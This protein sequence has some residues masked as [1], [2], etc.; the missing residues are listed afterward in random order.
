MLLASRGGWRD[1]SYAVAASLAVILG[2][3]YLGQVRGWVQDALPGHYR[4]IVAAIV[5]LGAGAAVV[6][7]VA[8][9]RDRKLGRYLLLAAA[10]G[11]AVA[12]A[13]GARTGNP[14]QRSRRAVPFRR[15]RCGDLPVP[16]GVAASRRW[17]GAGAAAVRRPG[18]G[19]SDEWFQWFVP[20]R[21]GELHDVLIN[22]VAVVC[23]LLF[24]L[25]VHPPMLRRRRSL[26]GGGRS[27]P[28]AGRG[29]P[30]GSGVRRFGSSRLRGRRSR[31]GTFRSRFDRRGADAARS[32]ARRP[33]AGAA[34]AHL[35]PGLPA[36]T[37]T[38][39]K[40]QWH[41]QRRNEAAR[42]N[43][44]GGRAWHENTILETFFTPVLDLGFRW[45]PDAGGSRRQA[46]ALPDRASYR[47][48][49][50]AISDH[51][52]RQIDLWA[53]VALIVAGLSVLGFGKTRPRSRGFAS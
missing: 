21:V 14:D 32:R 42:G 30:D 44:L 9:I 34:A 12:Y 3:P 47:S 38:W 18:R 39:P 19:D 45:A 20:S 41:V 35:A 23:G 11:I 5:V 40:A 1:L 4:W 31:V 33:L 53:P 48:D 16:P 26:A 52:H 28:G 15:V 22:A 2:A 46:N 29:R 13:R 49:A 43:G 37:I 10:L 24:S 36:R 25:G 17:S 51:G 27:R 7:A 6:A 50:D 8:R